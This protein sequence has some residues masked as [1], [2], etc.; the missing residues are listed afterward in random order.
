M[1]PIP[2]PL[3][4]RSLSSHLSS[5]ASLA[6]RLPTSRLLSR[7]SNPSI[8]PSTYGS[9]N[10]GPAP[11][12]VVGIVLGSVGGFLLILWLIYTCMNFGNWSSSSSYTESVVIRDRRKSH[13]SQR[14]RRVSE[15]VEVR[16]ERSPIRIVRDEPRREPVERVVVEERRE[17][18]RERSR[19]SD[20]VIVIEDHSPPPRRSKSKRDRHDEE[21][22]ESGFR[23]VDPLAYGGV[24]GG[25]K[26]SGRR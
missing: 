8:I 17:A 26:S 23:T 22:R 6:K 4:A 11:G 19:S 5:V 3:D 16:R 12:T 15:T 20:E 25:R 10:S 9:I 14:S 24:V 18:R 7:Q 21:R 2:I 1:A 13:G